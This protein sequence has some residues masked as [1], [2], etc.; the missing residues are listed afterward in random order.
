MHSNRL[1]V[2]LGG[3]GEVPGVINQ[4]GSWVILDPRWRSS[5]D[6][7]T[8]SELVADGHVFLICSNLSLPFPDGS[9]DIVY[10]NGVPLDRPSLL[11]PG[12]QTSELKRIL[13]SGGLWSKDDGADLWTK[14]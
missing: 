14:P 9:V 2:N 13:K 4:Q 8:F 10:T 3:E 11:G 6:G 12:V 1:V 7:K 5:R